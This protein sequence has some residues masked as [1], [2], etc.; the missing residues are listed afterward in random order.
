[1]RFAALPG[2]K[3]HDAVQ[4]LAFAHGKGTSAPEAG[5]RRHIAAPECRI[6]TDVR[7]PDRL[8]GGPDA[9]DEPLPALKRPAPAVVDESAG[10][11]VRRMPQVDKTKDFFIPAPEHAQLPV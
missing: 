3:L 9:A 1:I 6:G 11:K 4:L 5:F 7:N 10:V 2:E 8:P